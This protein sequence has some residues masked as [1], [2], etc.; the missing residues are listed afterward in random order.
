MEFK[1]VP[2]EEMSRIKNVKKK[3]ERERKEMDLMHRKQLSNVRVVQKNLVYVLGL[4]ARLAVEEV[5]ILM[6]KVKS[7]VRQAV[8]KHSDNLPII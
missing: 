7:L 8:L 1:P 5:M 3:K 4:P 2:I 6:L